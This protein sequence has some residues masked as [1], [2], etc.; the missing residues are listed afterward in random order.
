LN[1]RIIS[2]FSGP[3]VKL[4]NLLALANGEQQVVGEHTLPAGRFMVG[5]S[6]ASWQAGPRKQNMIAIAMNDLRVR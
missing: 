1:G 5:N 2:P 3:T 6:H 4:K